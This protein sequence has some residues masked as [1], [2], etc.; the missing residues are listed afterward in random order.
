MKQLTFILVA[1]ILSACSN[2]KKQKFTERIIKDGV[3]YTQEVKIDFVTETG[4]IDSPYL[5]SI[6]CT[7]LNSISFPENK[8]QNAVKDQ[9]VIPYD[10]TK[11][12]IKSGTAS[13]Y[14][15]FTAYHFIQASE[16]YNNLMKEFVEPN[17][18]DKDKNITVSIADQMPIANNNS[19]FVYSQKGKISPS[20]IYHKVGHRYEAFLRE[21]TKAKYQKNRY[22]SIGFMEYFTTSLNN[23]PLIFEGEV[24]PLMV[25]DVSIKLSYP[26]N[27]EYCNTYRSILDLKEAYSDIYKDENSTMH[28]Y[29]D[30]V[31][32][33]KE[34]LKYLLD[35]HSAGMYISY[36]LWKIRETIGAKKAD[37][38]IMHAWTMLA[39]EAKNNT[40]FYE[41]NNGENVDD[42]IDWYTVVHALLKADQIDHNGENKELI[43]TI[44]TSINL[45]VERVQ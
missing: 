23:S 21:Y 20:P 39:D 11:S 4:E 8:L 38:L 41:A 30:I 15:I 37:H 9:E 34:T 16:Y 28:H 2:I 27:T 26:I 19:H 45:P 24:P 18:K 36:P 7:K 33:S 6:H 17:I 13:Y 10:L 1:L 25:R 31:L 3:E 42:T 5:N 35:T 22:I 32:K 29:I 14:A 44:F 43:R 12:D 40:T